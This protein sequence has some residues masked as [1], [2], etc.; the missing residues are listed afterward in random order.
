M[1]KLGGD[2]AA[3]VSRQLVEP[4]H[5]LRD[6]LGLVVDHLE[7]FV[8]TSTGPTPYPW[9][10]LQTLRHGLADAYLEVTQLARR[11]EEL[12]RALAG[13]AP[14]WFDLAATVDLGVRLAGHHLG[15]NIELMIDLGASPPVRGA[16][17]TVALLIAHLVS[18]SAES[19]R[20]IVGSSLCVRVAAEPGSGVVIIADNGNGTGRAAELGE[21][22]RRIVVPWG[23]SAEVASTPGQGCAF[24]LRLV[25]QPDAESPMLP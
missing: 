14:Q 3:D 22:A 12:D 7:R 16:P 5:R 21:L 9:R 6:R 10:S 23:G 8:A 17:G 13:D 11:V 24:E 4:L 1:T 15:S 20:E 25:A 19:A 18:A 2:I